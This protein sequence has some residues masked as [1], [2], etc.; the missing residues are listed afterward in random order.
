MVY[1]RALVNLKTKN[2]IM[3]LK[4][5]ILGQK[6]CDTTVRVTAMQALARWNSPYGSNGE[7]V[8]TSLLVSFFINF[9]IV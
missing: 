7:E 6:E 1:V 5:Y 3:A 8:Y 9:L 4:P 2:A